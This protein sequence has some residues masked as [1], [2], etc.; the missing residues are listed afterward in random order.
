MRVA[1]M[2]RA[3]A[4]AGALQPLGA[5]LVEFCPAR[6]WQ[7]EALAE[8][9]MQTQDFAPAGGPGGSQQQREAW[10]ELTTPSFRVAGWCA[11]STA[12]MLGCC[13]RQG[14]SW[15]LGAPAQAGVD[16]G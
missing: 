4:W 2:T 13:P 15:F 12:P 8:K 7:D 11:R 10:P 1:R 6:S 9:W 5:R 16:V 14:V 3:V